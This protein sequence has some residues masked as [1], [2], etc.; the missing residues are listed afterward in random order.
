M[1]RRS[2]H[3][4]RLVLLLLAWEAVGPPVEEEGG[5]E[6][7]VTQSFQPRYLPPSGDRP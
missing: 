3:Y 7:W 5:Y 1:G 6:V 4:G 2:Q